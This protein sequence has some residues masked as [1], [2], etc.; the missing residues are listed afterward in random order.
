[1][2][3]KYA[4][5]DVT[6]KVT[7][8]NGVELV[9]ERHATLNQIYAVVDIPE[10]GVIKGDIGG[11]I[12]SENNLSHEDSCWLR[13]YSEVSGEAVVKENAIIDSFSIIR[14][15]SIIGKDVKVE[16]NSIIDNSTILNGV[17]INNAAIDRSHLNG[18]VVVIDGLLHY[19]KV[20]GTETASGIGVHLSH[21]VFMKNKSPLFITNKGYQELRLDEV[22]LT[23]KDSSSRH[24]IRGFGYI[25][26]VYGESVSTFTVNNEMRIQHVNLSGLA[27]LI[28]PKESAYIFLRG[29]S[30]EKFI[31][32]HEGTVELSDSNISG[33]LYVEGFV[34]ATELEASDFV[35][36]LNK[37]KNS[38]LHIKNVELRELA[39]LI[40]SAQKHPDAIE[41]IQMYLDGES[42]IYVR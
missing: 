25:R 26:N 41:A 13:Q 30:T 11:Y 15:R 24:D 20:E 10:H 32:F 29:E 36:I 9:G 27:G 6:K 21:C 34:V 14:G 31:T 8:P 17:K 40:H 3:K 12:E 7:I 16:E 28:A 23:F 1:M 18:R 33:Q 22:R 38:R 37:K 5:N 19:A 42:K 39:T 4:F 35:V 2:M